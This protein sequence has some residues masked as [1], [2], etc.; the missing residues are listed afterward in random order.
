MSDTEYQTA[1]DEFATTHAIALG[2]SAPMCGRDHTLTD[3]S[4]PKEEADTIAWLQDEA[5][6]TCTACLNEI[7]G[8]NPEM[9]ATLTASTWQA[10][11][12]LLNDAA[13]AA[14]ERGD[15]TD[16]DNFD[17]FSHIVHSAVM[18]DDDLT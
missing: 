4:E 11:V 17:A 18:R 15:I 12:D 16:A 2:D 6:D 1:T 14:R 10:I 7:L 9:T 8:I 13:W 5:P 3:W